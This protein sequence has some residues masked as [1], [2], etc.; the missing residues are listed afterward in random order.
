MKF[1]NI[2]IISVITLFCA[3]YLNAK[4]YT[5]TDE[6]GVKH[7][8]DQPPEN[9]E[10]YEVQTESKTFEY[11]EEA[12]QQRTE[13]DQEQ[14]QSFIREE[15]EKFERRQ[16]EK[17][18]KAQEA[19]KNRPPTQEEKIAAEMERLEAKISYLEGQPLEYFGNELNRHRYLEHYRDRLNMLLQDPSKYFNKPDNFQGNIKIPD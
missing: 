19:K 6:Q 3:S 14:L 5:W 15:D 2:L 8:S 17:R 10:N 1:F 16:Q 9:E 18:L 13:G 12:D 4:I 7:Y 11:D